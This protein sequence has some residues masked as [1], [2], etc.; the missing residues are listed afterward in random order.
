MKQAD[1]DAVIETRN[2]EHV[3]EIVARFA[4]LGMPARL[5]GSTAIEGDVI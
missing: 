4:A 3:R 2:A 5:L 1:L